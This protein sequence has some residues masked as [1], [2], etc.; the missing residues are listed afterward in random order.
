MSQESSSRQRDRLGEQIFQLICYG[1][2]AL[3]V[4]IAAALILTL[5]VEA[6][7]I[8][9]RLPEYPLVTS[10][11]WNPSRGSYGALVF[12]YG[13]VVTSLIAMLIAL[14]LGVGAAAY[15]SELASPKVRQLCSILLELLAAI[16][17]VIYGFWA[18]EFLAREGL[19]PTFAALGLPNV[20]AGQGLLAAGIVLAVMILPYITSV[21]F[22]VCRAVPRSQREAAFAL[23]ATRWQV[24]SRVV[25]P[26]ARP[27]ILAAAILALGRALGETMAVT[28]V[29]GNSP[30]IDLRIN[31][32]G[33]TIPSV[34]AKEL[35]EADGLHKAA[36][37]ALGLLLLAIT[38]LINTGG[39]R[40][41]MWV[42]QPRARPSR[43]SIHITETLSVDPMPKRVIARRK[44]QSRRVDRVMRC[45]L[46]LC[47]MLTVVPLFLI[48]GY[49]TVRGAPAVDWDFFTRLP[50]DFPGR[51]LKHAIVGSVILVSLAAV[52]AV[53]LGILTAILLAEF[54]GSRFTHVVRSI[55]ELLSGVPSIVLGIFGYALLVYPFWG[56]QQWGFSAWAGAFALAVM[57]LP[58]VIRV[59]EEALRLV[60]QSI[61]EAS[62]ALGAS[63]RQTVFK[64]VL[65]AAMPGILTGVMLS[66]ARI[67]GET[68]P[69]VL[70]ARGSQFMPRSLSDPT[71][72]LPFYIYEFSRYAPGSD[73]IRLAWAAAFV[74]VVV[75]MLL[76][77]G[78][79]L[80]AGPRVVA[81]ARAD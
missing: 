60:P 31:G 74:L 10:V 59:S 33:D 41:V 18:R 48:L 15:L 11:D 8:L 66:V 57:M 16:P 55:A 71:P 24:I 35:F 49:I 79:R 9:S 72:S 38:L 37:V 5:T 26:Y 56:T 76:N 29:I 6:W 61:R 17:S 12:V 20:A 73:Q 36:L 23:G 65:P 1:S 75:I 52:F 22:D 63:H 32:T 3:I 50:N 47:Q 69:L 21:S 80:L 51:G 58:V 81:A 62:Y 54:R 40:L 25:I 14:P 2:G 13:S 43:T 34:I 44:A 39:R 7:P 27:G 70:T 30:Y 68:A 45:L 64:V 78:V 67:A 53:P 28:M 4:G 77:V 46:V 19:A 42:S